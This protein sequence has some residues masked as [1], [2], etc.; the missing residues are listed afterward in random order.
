[1]FLDDHGFASGKANKLFSGPY[2]T[3]SGGSARPNYDV[4]PDGF[5]ETGGAAGAADAVNVVPGWSE[6]VRR[7]MSRHAR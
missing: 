7:L 6:E 3:A 1:V 4:F 5:V 2:A